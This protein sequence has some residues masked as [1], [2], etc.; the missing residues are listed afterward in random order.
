[1]HT[2]FSASTEVAVI[3]YGRGRSPL[4]WSVINGDTRFILNLFQYDA[5]PDSPNVFANEMFSIN[6][7]DTIRTLQYKNILP[8]SG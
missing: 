7:H 3:C 1:M 8:P 4:N 5:D 6:P 2:V